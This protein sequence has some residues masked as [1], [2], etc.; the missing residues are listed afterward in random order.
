M[1]KLGIIVIAFV[2]VCLAALIGGF[3]AYQFNVN[4]ASQVSD[5]YDE[6][7]ASGLDAGDSRG[8]SRGLSDG[9]SSGYTQGYGAGYANGT[10]DAPKPTQAPDRYSEGYTAGVSSGKSAGYSDG[11]SKGTA[12]GFNTGYSVGYVNGS[13]DGAG[14]GYNIRDPTYSEMLSFIAVD[15]TDKNTYSLSYDCHD[16][17]RDVLINAF[18]AGLKGGYVYVEFAGG[19][20]HALVCFDTVDKGLI[21]VE[22]QSDDLMAVTVGVQYWERAIY[23]EPNYDDTIVQFDIIW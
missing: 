9:V 1:S 23:E 6:G 13:K 22:P 12:D 4:G 5:R 19:L 14:S 7:Y 2:V 20:A 21:Y 8:Y 11:Y 18:N 17:T 15:Q 3:V 16:F 10:L